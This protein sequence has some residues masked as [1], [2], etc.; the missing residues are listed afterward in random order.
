M[1]STSR[2]T[3]S[4]GISDMPQAVHD[5]VHD[6]MQDWSTTNHWTD[7]EEQESEQKLKDTSVDVE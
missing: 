7:S 6:Q 4:F 2:N 5:G 1:D 3:D